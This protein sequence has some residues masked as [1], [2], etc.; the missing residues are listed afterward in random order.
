MKLKE[1]RAKTKTAGILRQLVF[2][3]YGGTIAAGLSYF[4]VAAI[5]SSQLFRILPRSSAS[6]IVTKSQ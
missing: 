4:L 6:I 1:S 2:H 3:L 5:F